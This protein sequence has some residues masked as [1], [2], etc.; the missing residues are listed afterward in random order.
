MLN[1]ENII[2][3]ILILKPDNDNCT[4]QSIL[5][6]WQNDPNTLNT[7]IFDVIGWIE[8][9]WITHFTNCVSAPTNVNDTLNLSCLGSFGGPVMPFVGLGGYP[10]ANSQHPQYGN[11]SA[12]VITFIINN[13]LNKSLNANAMAWEK[14][15]INYLKAYSNPNMTVS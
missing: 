12:L 2:L 6:Y 8:A 13:H 1:F 11:A 9:D 4:I 15:V 7:T 10:D 5:N 3:C 14:A